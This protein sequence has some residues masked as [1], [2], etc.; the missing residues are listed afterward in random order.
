MSNGQNG[1]SD[2]PSEPSTV[3]SVDDARSQSRGIASRILDT[4]G[5]RGNVTDPGPGVS[6]CSEDPE[7]ERLYL[8]RHPWSIYGLPRE[9]LDEGMNRLRRELPKQGWRI[10]EDGELDNPDRSP[11]I[12][13][14]NTD[15]EY[16][17]NVTIE[18]GQGD[19]LLHFSMVSGCFSTPEGESPRD[20]Y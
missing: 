12:L 4:T 1:E 13:F 6:A 17:A 15:L 10:L 11:R 7:M 3:K 20:E 18:G 5:I 8:M 19:P 2:K 16:A 14:Q 9:T